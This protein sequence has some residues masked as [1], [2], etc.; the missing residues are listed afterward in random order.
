MPGDRL[1]AAADLCGGAA[2]MVSLAAV[3]ERAQLESA[4]LCICLQSAPYARGCC[5][6]KM[7][8]PVPPEQSSPS[9]VYP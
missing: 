6:L 2:D 4:D 5:N 3:S 8:A 1:G 7:R 9:D